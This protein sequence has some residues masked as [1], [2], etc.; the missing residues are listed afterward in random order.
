MMKINLQMEVGQFVIVLYINETM[1]YFFKKEPKILA[2]VS[3]KDQ[4]STN[5]MEEVKARVKQSIVEE[6]GIS[7]VS[8]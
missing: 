7:N 2:C 6:T 4:L 5:E 3:V 8:E 1:P